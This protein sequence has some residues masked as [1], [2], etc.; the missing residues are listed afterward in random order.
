MQQVD[1]A[2]TTGRQIKAAVM[3]RLGVTE[4]ADP[5]HKDIVKQQVCIDWWHGWL[6]HMLLH[7]C[8][9][10]ATLYVHTQMDNFANGKKRPAKATVKAAGPKVPPA[11]TR[12][13]GARVIVVGAGPA[14][15]TAALHLQRNGVAATV[16]EAR[17][18]IGGRVHS[19]EG[20]GFSVPVDLGA[21]LIT[22]GLAAWDRSRILLYTMHGQRSMIVQAHTN[23][24][25]V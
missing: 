7:A 15:L 3:E 9:S 12:Q 6:E 23:A 18:R 25:R 8:P 4:W 14:G 17:D 24:C 5:K 10:T 16:L 1:A 11:P 21:S 2:T 19:F 20:S 13:R 22:G